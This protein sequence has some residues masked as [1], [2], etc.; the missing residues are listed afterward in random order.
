MVTKI[1]ILKQLLVL[2]PMTT[3][4]HKCLALL[5]A[6]LSLGKQDQSQTLTMVSFS[7]LIKRQCE[8]ELIWIISGSG[9]G[10][11]FILACFQPV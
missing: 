3:V 11:N 5:N 10:I 4:G 9:V 2:R 8:T 1:N 7:V 6:V